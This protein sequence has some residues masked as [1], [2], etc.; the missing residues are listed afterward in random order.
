MP[1]VTIHILQYD[2]SVLQNDTCIHIRS[3]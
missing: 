3:Q 1:H 2:L